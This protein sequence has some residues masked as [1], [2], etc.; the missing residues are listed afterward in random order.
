MK[1]MLL[2]LAFLSITVSVVLTVSTIFAAEPVNLTLWTGYAECVPV[3]RAAASDYMN[4]H[5]DVNIEV[6]P[7]EL[8][9]SEQKY[10]IALPSGT[11]P[12][13]FLT[14]YFIANM[15][16]KNGML[17]PAPAEVKEWLYKN[18]DLDYLDPFGDGVGN[19]YAVP[20][21]QGFQVLFYNLDYYAEAGLTKPPETLD[22]LMDYARKLVKYD[23]KGNL[24]RS[25]ISL[26][27]SGGGAGIAQKFDNFLFA[28]GGSVLEPTT[29][30]KFKANFANEAGYEALNFYLQALHKY[31][32]DS[33]D[34]K[35]DSEAFV[36]GLT[37]QFNRETYV[38]GEVVKHSPEMNYGITQVVGGDVQRATNLNG[39]G[40]I[41]P[42]T[43]KN[44]STAWDFLMYLNQDKY[45]VQ[46]IRDVGWIMSKKDVDYSEVYKIEPHFEQVLDRPE[47][48]K[49]I[50][51]PWAVSFNEVYTKFSSRLV[52]AF[53]DASMVDNK[54]KIMKFLED[55]EKEANDILKSNDEYGE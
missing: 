38:I 39:T 33:Y 18:F 11:A 19:I 26:R 5:P 17:D 41:L 34:I 51:A 4:E 14:S 15:Y 25:G 45:C 1:K 9:Q 7:F 21:I 3:Y 46:M 40:W 29:N 6:T 49:M 47:N 27:I 22:E 28:N 32:V 8:R 2:I 48:F 10:A 43:G 16:V 50:P 24:I 30:G 36:L 35:H 53:S 42:A 52:E 54:E 20:D 12:D 55:A 44:N 31:K 37:A 13:L 23:N